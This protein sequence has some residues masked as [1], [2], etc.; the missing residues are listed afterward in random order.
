MLKM[1][2]VFWAAMSGVSVA[3]MA[4]TGCDLRLGDSMSDQ[5]GW[6]TQTQYELPSGDLDEASRLAWSPR[7][8]TFGNYEY[9][10]RMA[11]SHYKTVANVATLEEFEAA[12]SNT[13]NGPVRVQLSRPLIV[14]RPVRIMVDTLIG[15]DSGLA[16][17]QSIY[18]TP[19]GR[20]E[21][22]GN[23]G[24]GQE[25]NCSYATS[26]GGFR[27]FGRLA[28]SLRIE[29]PMIEPRIVAYQP[30]HVVI[31]GAGTRRVRA[32]LAMSSWLVFESRNSRA[33]FELDD[34]SRISGSRIV[35]LNGSIRA[36]RRLADSDVLMV[37]STYAGLDAT[38]PRSALS[39]PCVSS[40]FI[41]AH[42]QIEYEEPWVDA[43]RA[44]YL[45]AQAE[46]ACRRGA[47]DKVVDRFKS[48]GGGM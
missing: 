14:D 24:S 36:N 44:H 12:V 38:S 48:C 18:F 10:N 9:D 3:A 11:R 15:S 46:A 28:V 8:T 2:S 35:V 42:A 21:L 20:F 23:T 5:G 27:T 29:E 30:V 1:N 25:F 16:S 31:A 34:S 39:W 47:W 45:Y 40:D 19:Q 13:T 43:S 4:L 22:V 32:D 17:G 41:P 37:R 33:E 7:A 6:P 26:H